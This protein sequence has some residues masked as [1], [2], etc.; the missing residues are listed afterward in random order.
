M[1]K[2][3]ITL[4]AVAVTHGVLATVTNDNA[5][6][7]LYV[8][9]NAEMRQDAVDANTA[10]TVMTYTDTAGT[11]GTKGIYDAS[12][13]YAEQQNLLV[14]A[15][16]AN[17]AIMNAINMEFTCAEYNP[18]DDTDCWKWQIRATEVPT[19]YTKLEYL[20]STGTQYIDTGLRV[21]SNTLAE[22][23]YQFTDTDSRNY[24]FGQ[25][26]GHVDSVMGYR[27]A[28]VLRW[29]R[30]NPSVSADANKH[31]V[32]FNADGNIYKDNE[33]IGTR[34]VFGSEQAQTMLIFAER[35]DNNAINKGRV[36]IYNFIFKEG[37]RTVQ[38]LIPARRDSDG[39]LGMYD[40]ITNTFFTNAGTGTFIT[41]PDAGFLPQNQ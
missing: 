22:F 24:V 4:L 11:V 20:E 19:G 15:D 37:S 12:G 36:K 41:G 32:V 29:F 14:S 31:D 7:K 39:T 34:G 9:N 40:T 8:D 18:N 21:K 13:S 5:T 10:N 27:S 16:V 38:N 23:E 1:K 35:N 30:E 6:S 26:A 2:I 25:I 28:N 33:I 3:L 17:A